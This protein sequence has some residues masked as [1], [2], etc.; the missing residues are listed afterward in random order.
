[1]TNQVALV[2]AVLIAAAL[3]VD[4]LWNGGAAA[5]FLAIRFLALVEWVAFWR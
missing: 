5:M 4:A 3:G 1:M 2:I